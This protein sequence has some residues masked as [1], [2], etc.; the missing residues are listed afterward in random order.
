MLF[1]RFEIRHF[2]V[3]FYGL[4]GAIRLAIHKTL[5]AVENGALEP[6]Y[7][8]TLN[9]CYASVFILSDGIYLCLSQLFGWIFVFFWTSF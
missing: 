3:I 9:G 2:F 5:N 8:L 7:H 4:K 6:D 1:G